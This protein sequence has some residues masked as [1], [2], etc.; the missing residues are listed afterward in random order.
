[1]PTLT[2]LMGRRFLILGLSTVLGG[3]LLLLGIGQLG[4]LPTAPAPTTLSLSTSPLAS[5]SL[6]ASSQNL[7]PS[8][9]SLVAPEDNV[10]VQLAAKI[11]KEILARNPDGP[12]TTQDGEKI[13]LPNVD[14]FIEQYLKDGAVNFDTTIFYPEVSPSKLYIAAPTV[15]GSIEEFT[16]IEQYQKSFD[17]I[18]NTWLLAL[19]V[20]PATDDSS[21]GTFFDN[22]M[23]VLNTMLQQLYALMTP[24]SLIQKHQQL[25]RALEG[26]RIALI[27]L[28]SYEADPLQAILTLN[29]LTEIN[30]EFFVV[31]N[32]IA[33]LI[34]APSLETL[35]P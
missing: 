8:L 27:K 4:L 29:L 24:Q 3:F 2:Q 34:S 18:F 30:G 33:N 11:A 1:M 20:P 10:T 15:P 5:V 35:K 17:E 13:V 22:A 23:S 6:A 14:G 21:L 31:K 26:T 12:R 25:L 19:S 32:S 28:R 7:S 16:A 9:P